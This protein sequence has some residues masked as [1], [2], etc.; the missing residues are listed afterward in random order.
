MRDPTAGVPRPGPARGNTRGDTPW[1]TDRDT[2][3]ASIHVLLLVLLLCCAGVVTAAAG[4]ALAVRHRAATAADLAALAAADHALEGP[5]SACGHGRTLARANGAHL[6]VCTVTGE[7]VD[8]VV[9]MP[10]PARLGG[11]EPVRARARAG[12]IGGLP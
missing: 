8:L 11:F 9:E 4:Q 2:G 12:P 5:G 7:I 1:L 3:S 6:V 10:L